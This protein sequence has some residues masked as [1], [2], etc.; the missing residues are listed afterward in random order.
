M[1]Q[2]THETRPTLRAAAH[3][4]LRKGNEVLLLRRYQTGY[5][6]GNYSTIAGHVENGESCTETAIREAKE[7]AGVQLRKEDLQLVHIMH[8]NGLN[9]DSIDT[10]F[11]AKRWDGEPKNVEPEKSD[12]VRWY[13][14]DALPEN[15]IPYIR[16]ALQQIDSPLTYSEFGWHN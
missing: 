1:T 8:R 10:F 3:V 16:A 6:D 11:V 14:V 7:E 12:D 13:P 5:E 4:F 15:T 2:N 9:F